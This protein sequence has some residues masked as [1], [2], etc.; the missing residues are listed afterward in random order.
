MSEFQEPQ[1]F[2]ISCRFSL[3][4]GIYKTYSK[5]SMH[6]CVYDPNQMSETHDAYAHY[7]TEQYT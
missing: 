7:T 1:Q 5:Y 3:D 4:T 6:L 2:S